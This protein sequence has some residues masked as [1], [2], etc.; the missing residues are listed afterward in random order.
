MRFAFGITGSM[1][2]HAAI[3]RSAGAVETVATRTGKTEPAVRSWIYRN[4]I[5][6]EVWSD[7]AREGWASLEELADTV[8]ERKVRAA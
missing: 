2:D 5:P 3:V 6:P 4:R 1:R 7:F 8:P